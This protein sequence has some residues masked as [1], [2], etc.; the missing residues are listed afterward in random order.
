MSANEADSFV[1][2]TLPVRLYDI[3]N[4]SDFT[5]AD[6]SDFKLG[7]AKMFP[8]Q[9]R[10]CLFKLQSSIFSVQFQKNSSFHN[11]I[12]KIS[13]MS[14]LNYKAQ[15]FQFNFEGIRVYTVWNK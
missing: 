9:F 3:E 10:P 1:V 12:T 8:R 5:C 7:I 6:N 2:V 11:V 13:T 15:Y 4:Q 14:V